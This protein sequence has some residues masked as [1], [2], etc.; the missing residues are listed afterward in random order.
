MFTPRH[1][2]LVPA[3]PALLLALLA[4]APVSAQ[5][6]PQRKSGLWEIKTQAIPAKNPP[7]S[8]HIFVDTKSADLMQHV[9]SGPT[10]DFCLTTERRQCGERLI[11][12]SEC[13]IGETMATTHSVF[14]GKFDSA[15][16]VESTSKYDP[17]L[18]GIKEGSVAI[19]ATWLGP[20]KADQKPGDMVLSN[21]MKI[22]INGVPGK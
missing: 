18:A 11:I 6:I 2:L 22:N 3:A 13:K 4:A 10:M 8:I 7:H 9:A 5:G 19:E 15:Y 21:G 16:R 20:C 17:P 14:T 12:G 1:R